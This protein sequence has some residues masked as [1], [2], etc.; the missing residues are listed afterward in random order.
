MSEKRFVLKSWNY[1]DLN[2]EIYD[3]LKKEE[4]HLSL[5]GI[6]NLLNEVSQS[7]YTL[8][9]LKEDIIQKLDKIGD[10]E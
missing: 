6:M 3:N 5:Y 7:E 2:G 9:N 8:Y 10:M 4:L 1:N